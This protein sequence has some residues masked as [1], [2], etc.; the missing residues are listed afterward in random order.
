MDYAQY[1]STV[2]QPKCKE[3][4]EVLHAGRNMPETIFKTLEAYCCDNSIPV[5]FTP[6]D[7]A[8]QWGI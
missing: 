8:N 2:F 4:G 7:I 1:R 3:Y 6:K 5:T